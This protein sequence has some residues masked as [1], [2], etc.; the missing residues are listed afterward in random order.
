[1]SG[2]T[3]KIFASRLKNHTGFSSDRGHNQK[4]KRLVTL[5]L[6]I[7]PYPFWA[8]MRLI[9]GARYY[10]ED[11]TGSRKAAYLGILRK[12]HSKT[13]LKF[14]GLRYIMVKVFAWGPFM[15][16]IG[17]GGIGD[18]LGPWWSGLSDWFDWSSRVDVRFGNSAYI[19][20]A[21]PETKHDFSHGFALVCC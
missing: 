11:K 10:P 18:P 13:P 14:T 20:R 2:K 9:T 8:T 5:Q 12:G 4:K 1:M 6:Q 21:I 15:H 19:L 7:C 17:L 3:R 16:A